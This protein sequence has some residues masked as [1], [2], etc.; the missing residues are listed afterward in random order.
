MKGARVDQ[1][2]DPFSY[3]ELA[4]CVLA[5]DVFR[6]AH[7]FGHIRAASDFF[8]LFFPAQSNASRQSIAS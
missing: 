1:L 4:V 6:A 8:N 5:R 7:L 2:L 3:G